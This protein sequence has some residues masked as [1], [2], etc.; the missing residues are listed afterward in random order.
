MNNLLDSPE[1]F[2]DHIRRYTA[3]VA[4]SLTYGYRA[5]TIASFWAYVRGLFP[6]HT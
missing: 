6:T 4:S 1:G 5:A 3:S 2:Y